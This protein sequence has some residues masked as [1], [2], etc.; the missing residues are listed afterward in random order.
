MREKDDAVVVE[1]NLKEVVEK[2]MSGLGLELEENYPDH[3]VNFYSTLE[4]NVL[5]V[6]T[7][8]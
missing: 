4:N 6:L 1:A 8:K 7:P 2:G 3:A 5:F